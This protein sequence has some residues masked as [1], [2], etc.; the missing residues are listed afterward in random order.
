MYYVLSVESFIFFFSILKDQ[1]EE[2]EK[3]LTFFCYAIFSTFWQISS[4]TSLKEKSSI[5]EIIIYSL[6]CNAYR[7]VMECRNFLVFL[8]KAG[9]HDSE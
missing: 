2:L 3:I 9:D 7:H 8:D 1:C 5:D 4:S 6:L